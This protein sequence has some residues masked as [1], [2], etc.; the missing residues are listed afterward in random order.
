MK[1]LDT[2]F[3]PTALVTPANALTLGRVIST[4]VMLAFIVATGA[5]WPAFGLW[6]VLAGTDGLDGYLARRH[7]TTLSGAFLDPLADKLL[8]IGAMF[9]LVGIGTFWWFPVALVASREIVIS[10]YRSLMARRGISIPARQW[11]KVKTF[12]QSVA[13]GFAL[14]PPVADRDWPAVGMLWVAVVL[15]LITGA[16]YLLDGRQA[17]SNAL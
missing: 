11:A 8:V 2:S 7:G 12:V 9:A 6:V 16:N 10:V 1:R 15:T 17:A 3:G 4:P 13:V 5:S 14:L